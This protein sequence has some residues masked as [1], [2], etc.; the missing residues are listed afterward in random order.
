MAIGH[1]GGFRPNRQPVLRVG[2][3]L[4]ST[5]FVIR[6][7]AAVVGGDSGGPLFDMNGRVVGI[8][9]RIGGSMTD[10][11][12][13]PVKTYR[14]TWDRLAKGE[15]WGGQLG[16]PALVHSPGGKIIYDKEAK[17]IAADP[18]DSK[19]PGCHFQLHTVKMAPGSAYTIDMIRLGAKKGDLKKQDPKDL[20]PYL[21]LEDSNGKFLADDDDGGGNLNARI[22]FWPDKAEDY[23]IIATTFEPDQFGS[24]VLIVRKVEPKMLAGKIDVLPALHMP[25]TA[26]GTLIENVRKTGDVL[27]ASGTV[28][29]AKGK[30]VSGKAIEFKWD[31]GNAKMKSDDHGVVFLQLSKQNARNLTLEVPD[32]LRIT[33]ALTDSSGNPR[34][35]PEQEKE[36]V[37]SAG[38]KLVLEENG[39]LTD[40]DAKDKIRDDMA[41]RKVTKA[42]VFKLHTIKMVP[43]STYTIDL[44]S[45]DF[46]AYLR[47]EDPSGKQVAE[48]DDGAGSLNSRIVYTPQS[49]GEYRIIVTTCDPDQSGA[50]R[51]AVLQNEAKRVT[52]DPKAGE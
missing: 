11:F 10:N 12:H 33:L 2:R 14:D 31:K 29:D 13:V 18:K 28:V 45:I 15:S 37:K 26:A 5:Q 27:F 42:C 20:D 49:E 35:D 23:R 41:K 3:V 32:G 6:S 9:S 24:Y 22:V 16:M 30:P 7:D 52:T 40:Q 50:Y 25:R 21:R 38:G 48:D 46:D 44:Q 17:M 34:N 51:L 39:V 47:L 43:G 1:P 36:T 4:Q 8:H 19:R